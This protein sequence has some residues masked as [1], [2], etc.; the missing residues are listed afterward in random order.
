MGGGADEEQRGVRQSR[1][2]LREVVNLR[3]IKGMNVE[4]RPLERS[5]LQ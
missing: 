3:I 4:E 2:F 1:G 5:L